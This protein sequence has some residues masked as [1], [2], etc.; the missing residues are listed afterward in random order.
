MEQLTWK[1]RLQVVYLYF[2]GLS[3]GQIAAK[4][5]ISHGSVVNIIN[6]LK[7][8]NFPEAAD[9]VDQIEILRDLAIDLHKLHMSA[10]KSAVGIAVFKRIYELNLD[11]AD[12]ERWPLLINSI[13]TQDDAQELIEAAY[14]VRDLEHEW[15]LS[16]PAIEDKVNQLGEKAKELKI[17]AGNIVKAKTQ[18][19]DLNIKKEKLTTEV[20]SL[21]GK[22]KWL[23]PRVHELE[24]REKLLLDR[25]E[26][27]LIEA[28]K[29]KEML[30]TLKTE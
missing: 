25:H 24:Q 28:E 7:A 12:M 20:A 17:L 29:A 8:G 16:L 19:K 14:N 18:I 9:V 2:S 1:K 21:D 4:T 11:P 26:A 23:I 6:E 13:K 15:N 10:G 30:S 27:M 22:F 5:G 3:F